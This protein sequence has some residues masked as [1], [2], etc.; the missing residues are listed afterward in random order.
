MSMSMRNFGTDIQY[1][2]ETFEL[3]LIFKVGVSTTLQELAGLE[4]EVHAVNLFIDAVHPNDWSERVYLGTEYSFLKT[5]F[6]R[7]GYKFNHSAEGLALGVGVNVPVLGF[8]R[9]AVDYAYKD[10]KD[11]GFEGIHVVSLSGTL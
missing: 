6:L 9:L 8:G 11:S 3:P 4:S 10:T 7:A 1:Q 5:L 2:L